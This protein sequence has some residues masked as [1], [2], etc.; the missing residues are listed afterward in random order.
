[1]ERKFYDEGKL[2][3]DRRVAEYVELN[4]VNF[5]YGKDYVSKAV[6]LLTR[7]C[8]HRNLRVGPNSG[9]S[10]FLPIS[11]CEDERVLAVA[12]REHETAVERLEEYQKGE[13][14]F[15]GKP[16]EGVRKKSAPES[17][18]LEMDLLGVGL[19]DRSNDAYLHG[20]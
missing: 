5:Q 14:V 11:Q 12:R 9:G 7:I 16:K 20:R 2:N 17:T 8:G 18:Q 10:P 15:E 1:M 19:V 3:R 13:R 4:G 6:E